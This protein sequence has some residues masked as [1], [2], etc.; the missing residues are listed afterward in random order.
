MR[1]AIL[2]S[3]I[4]PFS[5][6]GG[7]ADVTGALADTLARHG[8]RVLTVSPRYGVV[9]A[10][11]HGF[12]PT[13]ITPRIDLAWRTWHPRLWV[14]RQGL[15]TDVLVESA[16]FDRAGIYGDSHGAFGDNHLRYALLSRAGIEAARLVPAPD[17]PLGE[18]VVFHVNDWHTALVPV[19]LNASYRPLG[20]FPRAPTVLT[21]HNL[22]HQGAFSSERFIDLELP[23]RW[24]APWCLEWHGGVN[25]L[26]GG[27]LQAEALTTVSETYAREIL[28][29]GGAF[30]LEDA[31]RSR[32]R[33][34]VGIRNGIDAQVWDPSNDP[35]LDAQFNAD[36]LSGK[37]VCKAALQAE[38]GLPVDPH[39]PLLGNIGRLDPQKGVQL[40]LDSVPWLVEA[41]GAQIVV[42]GS[43]GAANRHL[44]HQL[45]ALEHRYPRHVRAWIG[46][47]E[48]MAHRIEAGADLFMMPSLFEPCGLNQLYSLRYGTPPVVHATGGLVDS[49]QAHDP[50]HDE[51]TGWLFHHPTG[52]HLREALH[53]AIVTWRHH[54]EAFRRVQQR[55]M[56][57]DLSWD[58]VIPKYEHVYRYVARKLG[59][60][61]DA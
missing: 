53:W 56:R 8:H 1:V 37:A 33:D 7:L 2:T 34:L 4:V 12:H 51:G 55:G 54:P 17:V 5:K 50:R 44:E 13:D 46:F 24:H 57:Q 60:D 10:P 14:R 9:D 19:Y 27:V 11:A 45:R 30:G 35:H 18:D 16:I 59:M 49:V 26:Q 48:R 41:H 23:S 39:A 61:P 21:L 28:Y 52:E 47:S 40:L 20:L 3:E 6:T 58:A 42:L 29:D 36:D 38:L 31:L 15:R 25:L 32:A 22:A 43:A